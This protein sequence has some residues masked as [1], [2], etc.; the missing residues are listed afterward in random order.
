MFPIFLGGGQHVINFVITLMAIPVPRGIWLTFNV[1]L[2]DENWLRYN[3]YAKSWQLTTLYEP[4]VCLEKK[5]KTNS[6]HSYS[7]R[8]KGLNWILPAHNVSRNRNLTFQLYPKRN[9]DD[10][11]ILYTYIFYTLVLFLE[12]LSINIYELVCVI[13][14]LSWF[15]CHPQMQKRHDNLT[16]VWNLNAF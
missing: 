15:Y 13:L 11:Q 14:R 12:I 2:C 5:T 6:F 4:R 8:A 9:L 10:Y 3:P 1:P 7:R 16:L